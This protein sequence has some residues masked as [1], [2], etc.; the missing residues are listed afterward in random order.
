MN[1]RIVPLSGSKKWRRLLLSAQ[2]VLI[3]AC[4]R[5]AS[6]DKA[7]PSAQLISPV[8]SQ[9]RDLASAL[10]SASAPSQLPSNF[11]AYPWLSDPTIQSLAPVES[12]ASRFAPP[13]G[14]TR[15]TVSA[16]SFGAWLRNLP[17]T[18]ADEPV[19]SH[20]GK[21]LLPHDHPNIA[22]VVALD[23][24]AADLQ[25]CAD[26]VIRLHAEWQ[27]S[28]GVRNIGYEAAS[29]AAMPFE[30][31]AKGERP[32]PK[33]QSIVWEAKGAKPNADHGSFRKFLDSVFMF[34][35]TVALARQAKPVALDSIRPGDFVVQGGNP[36]GASIRAASDR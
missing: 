19:R 8:P 34:T 10:P 36:I 17:L 16:N 12:L 4:G 23:I 2:I 9:P 5:S 6:V 29:R 18:K 7:S 30:R 11:D 32:S 1:R 24:G 13:S 27:W 31:W 28:Q 21:V 25:Q 35:N 15:V 20:H 22:S 33:G 14:F 3:A 26:A